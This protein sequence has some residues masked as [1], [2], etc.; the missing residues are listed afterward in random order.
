MAIRYIEK[1]IVNSYIPLNRNAPSGIY[2]KGSDEF[3]KVLK[4]NNSLYYL[5]DSSDR[6]LI[7]DATYEDT[8]GYFFYGDAVII[9]ER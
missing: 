4:I 5:D 7:R 3:C 1:S 2:A 6:H 8:Q 9:C